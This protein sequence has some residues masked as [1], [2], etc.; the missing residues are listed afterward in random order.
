LWGEMGNTGYKGDDKRVTNY[1][2][3]KGHSSVFND[4]NIAALSVMINGIIKT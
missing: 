3:A 4:K 1:A 2:L